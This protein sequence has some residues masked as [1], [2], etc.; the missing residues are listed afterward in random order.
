MH[1][2]SLAVF[3]S[4]ALLVAAEA[5]A[6]GPVGTPLNPTLLFRNPR[7]LQAGDTAHAFGDAGG[8]TSLY[9]RSPDGGRSWPV[10]EQSLGAFLPTDEAYA[11][12]LLVAVGRGFGGVGV[13]GPAITVSN[14]FGVTWSPVQTVALFEALTLS[15]FATEEVRVHVAGSAITVVWAEPATKKVR[16]VHSAN[17]GATWS[18]ATLLYQPPSPPSPF[19]NSSLQLRLVRAGSTVHAF[20]FVDSQQPVTIRMQT[21]TDAGATW[22][23]ND[24]LVDTPGAFGV[25]LLAAGDADQLVVGPR[26]GSIARSA[27]GG[28][29]WSPVTGLPTPAVE[30]IA[31]DGDRVVVSSRTLD[32]FNPTR[33][34]STSLDG[35]ATW[36]PHW[37]ANSY[38]GFVSSA[39][40]DGGDLHVL[41][42]FPN[43]PTNGL[44]LR[45]EDGGLSWRVVANNVAGM[46][47]GPQR[48]IYLRRVISGLPTDYVSYAYVGLGSTPAGDGTAGTG[49]LVPQLALQG[50][51]ALGRTPDLALTQ[52]LGNTLGV[53]GVSS[54]P[55]GA[56]PFA[57]GLVRLQAPVALVPFA[58]SALGAWT[59]PLAVPNDPALRG[60]S[61]VA[62]SLLLDPAATDGLSLSSAIELWLAL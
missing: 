20:W 51:P 5:M 55:P 23:P 31:S 50:M 27:D 26:N 29:T 21:S 16:S 22:L 35:G 11:D 53:L 12:G 9:C 43:V 1:N 28:V 60:A 57:G 17:A 47:P 8:A 39:F 36:Q 18:G 49:G 62:Q 14:D 32:S 33:S 52:A 30:H 61:L 37:I 46:A 24:R 6:Q 44:L 7:L 38:P 4:F 25:E 54:A 13:G 59:A 56:I 3:A 34:I 42:A 10:V 45:S 58:T 2:G 41:F 15:S 19:N 48:N 40:V